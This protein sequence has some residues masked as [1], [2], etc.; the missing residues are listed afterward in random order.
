M[1][2]LSIHPREAVITV[3]RFPSINSQCIQIRNI[4][5]YGSVSV[6]MNI[7]MPSMEVATEVET[8]LRKVFPAPK[9][10]EPVVEPDYEDIF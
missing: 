6:E 3:Q 1:L 4:G 5:P 2:N 7:W 9:P 8:A 10:A